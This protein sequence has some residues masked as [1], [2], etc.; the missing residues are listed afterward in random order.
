MKV[1][2]CLSGQARTFD[3]CWPTIKENIIE[4]TNCDVYI[5]VC[6]DADTYKVL[7]SDVNYKG[8]LVTED[9]ELKFH[10]RLRQSLKAKDPDKAHNKVVQQLY[11]ISRSND[12]KRAT[13]TMLRFRYDW[14]I[15][16][17]MDI[18]FEGKIEDLSTL[19]PDGIYF[20]KHQNETGLNDRFAFGPSLYMDIY[21]N[22]L[23]NFDNIPPTIWNPEQ[24]LLYTIS[25][26]NDIKICRTD[27]IFRRIS[28]KEDGKYY[29][30]DGNLKFVDEE[31]VDD[32]TS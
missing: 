29:T 28:R 8:L 19:K 27:I 30:N 13:E 31:S 10:S 32:K 24:E 22:R 2:L 6:K 14:V 7:E 17:R 25:M 26:F 15:R 12:L 11:A 18:A 5:S 1:A 20:P 3:K 16:S 21:S 9:I 23:S 4:P